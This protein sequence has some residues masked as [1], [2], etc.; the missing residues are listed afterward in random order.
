MITKTRK[1]VR[2]CCRHSTC[3]SCIYA[4]SVSPPPSAFP[5]TAPPRCPRCARNTAA[6]GGGVGGAEG[7]TTPRMRAWRMSPDK[8]R[9]RFLADGGATFGA[10][11]A[12]HGWCR[13]SSMAIR[14]VRT[15]EHIQPHTP[16]VTH[17]TSTAVLH[18][19]ATRCT[20]PDNAGRTLP[21]SA[22]R[23]CAS[24]SCASPDRVLHVG[25]VFWYR[26][27]SMRVWNSAAPPNVENGCCTGGCYQTPI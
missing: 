25:S 18:T 8:R 20:P 14:W 3:P 2:H 27:F 22:F 15:H 16:P 11:G 19:T 23:S 21:M 4:A 1:I 9:P 17:T 5:F 10:N 26:A 24:K 6:L 13:M 7:G 12:N